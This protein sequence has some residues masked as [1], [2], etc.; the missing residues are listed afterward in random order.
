MLHAILKLVHHLQPRL[1]LAWLETHTGVLSHVQYKRSLL[2]RRMYMIIVLELH[3][4]QEVI[5]VILVLVHE[6]TQILLKLLVNPLCL[7]I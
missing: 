3:K 2:G 5:P 4:G 1:Q 6:E 7:P